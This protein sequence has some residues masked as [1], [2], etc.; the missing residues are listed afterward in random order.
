[1]EKKGT[2]KTVPTTRGKH[3]AGQVMGR[4]T[5]YRGGGPG[6]AAE[7]GDCPMPL[8]PA[9]P[10]WGGTHLS[11]PLPTNLGGTGPALAQR[12]SPAQHPAGLAPGQGCLVPLS[13]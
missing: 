11:P 9:E 7:L 4:D 6:K 5:G 2:G 3:R 10:G 8:L 12:E 1:M 13:R